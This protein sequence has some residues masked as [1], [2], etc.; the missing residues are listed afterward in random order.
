L[1]DQVSWKA[2]EPGAKVFSSE[3]EAVGKVS[4]VVGDA[5]ADVFTGLA[6][7]IETFGH[8]RFVASERVAGIYPDRIDLALTKQE[9]ERLPEHT[10]APAVRWRPE[11]RGGFFSRLFGRR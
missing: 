10:D 7:S 8:D 4:Q 3:G 1:T 9:I 5:N 6:L 2:I 11:E